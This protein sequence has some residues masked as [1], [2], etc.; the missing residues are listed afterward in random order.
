MT[1]AR[2]RL[3]GL[4]PPSG[5]ARTF[6][7][8]VLIDSLGTGL[9]VVLAPLYLT[10][11]IGLSAGDVGVGLG[12]AGLVGLLSAVPVGKL[13]DR[14]GSRKTL[15]LMYG[16]QAVSAGAVPFVASL[17]AFT[18]IACVGALAAQGA[19]SAQGALIAEIGGE[20]RVRYRSQL[21]AL[22]N[23][24]V[25]IGSALAGLVINADSR[26]A[27]VVALLVNALSFAAAAGV[28]LL[29]APG[30]PERRAAAGGRG[31]ENTARSV[32]R[33]FPY[34]ALTMVHG[35]L[36]VSLQVISLGLPLWIYRTGAG[37]AWLASV[38]LTLNTVVIVLFQV[39]VSRSAS[40]LSTAGRLLRH[41]GLLFLLGCSLP[42]LT[43]RGRFDAALLLAAAL[44]V[45]VGELL[46]TAGGFEVS[47]TL[48]PEGCQGQYQ[49]FFN[50]G[51]GASKAL[52]PVLVTFLCIDHGPA[53]WAVLGVA[54][55][56][57]ALAAPA[58]VRR[59]ERARV[60]PRRESSDPPCGRARS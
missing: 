47:M 51:Y 1:A 25:A 21:T 14:R 7:Y 32:L 37:P 13:A 26:A 19:R 36:S 45:T 38:I 49:G 9:Y 41:A 3:T 12:V 33:D 53:G 48:A 52:G 16:V 15:L 56:S 8:A 24:A 58:L 27:F 2:G 17:A 40:S 6:S 34:I 43:S 10:S 54:L 44:V 60:T 5:P 11:R 42:A 57:P 35:V 39:R 31:I 46:A 23:A 29:T 28:Q 55:C 50:L 18:V 30:T 22:S 59:A 4:L 20:Q